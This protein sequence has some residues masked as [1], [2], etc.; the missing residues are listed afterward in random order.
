MCGRDFDFWDIENNF[1]FEQ[2]I[3]Y[4]SEYDGEQLSLNLCCDCFDKAISMISPIC[5][6]HPIKE[7]S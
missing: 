7:V 1:C 3:G 5:K 2:N 4:G 6:V